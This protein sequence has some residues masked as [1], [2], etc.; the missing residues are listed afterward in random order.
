MRLILASASP[1][2]LDLLARIGVQPDAVD[3]ADI[4]ESVP[5]GRAAAR[6]CAAAG[7]RKGRSGRRAAMPTRWSWP[8]TR[9]SRSAGGSFPRSR[10]RRRCAPC[11][12]LLSGRR[13][14]V[15]TGV[16]ARHARSAHAQPG[17]RDDDRDEAAVDRK[18]STI[19]PAMANGM[20]RPAAMRCRAMAKSMSAISPAAIPM[21]SACPWPRPGCC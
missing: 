2:R 20:A 13:H 9:W 4:D 10:M 12:K 14:R 6:P 17:R 19:T 16:A 7:G 11:M 3:P 8:P 21:S 15:L 18:K 5:R 1:R